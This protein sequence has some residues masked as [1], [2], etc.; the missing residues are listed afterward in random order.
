M[1]K[2]NP[3]LNH[4]EKESIKSSFLIFLGKI[5][6]LSLSI[7]SLSRIHSCFHSEKTNTSQDLFDFFN[8]FFFSL[9]K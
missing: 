4:G 6:L 5:Y 2:Q 1:E 3:K 8:G 9:Y 7:L